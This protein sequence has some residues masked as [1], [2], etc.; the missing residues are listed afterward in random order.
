MKAFLL[1]GGVG[2]RLRPLTLKVPKPLM[3]F[4]ETTILEIIISR[5]VK[6]GFDEIFLSVGYLSDM[7][8][9]KI[10]SGENYGA[11][12]HY[13][14]EDEPL[15]TAGSL[16]LLNNMSDDLLV[17]NGDILT[18]LNFIDLKTFHLDSDNDVSLAV[19]TINSKFDYGVLT[20]DDDMNLIEYSEKPSVSIKISTGIYYLKPRVLNFVPK[21]NQDFPNLLTTLVN[22]GLRVRGMSFHGYWKDIGNL[23]DYETAKDDFIKNQNFFL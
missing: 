19:K 2:S 5:L 11:K 17:M 13:V 23:I 12:I 9:I 22:H 7:I 1:C 21:A 18:D 8:K 14:F 15:G 20:L 4:G 3:P 10:G 16:S 6:F